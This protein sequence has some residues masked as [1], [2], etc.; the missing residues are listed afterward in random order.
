MKRRFNFFTF[1]SLDPQSP[2][3]KTLKPMLMPVS[4]YSPE[5]PELSLFPAFYYLGLSN[6]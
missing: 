6:H 1:D 3:V 4:A 5:A 2:D